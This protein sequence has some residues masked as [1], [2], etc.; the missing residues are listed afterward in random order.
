MLT[1]NQIWFK[2]IKTEINESLLFKKLLLAVRIN[3]LKTIF[4]F[5]YNRRLDKDNMINFSCGIN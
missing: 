3:S 2:N 1:S 5:D 4:L